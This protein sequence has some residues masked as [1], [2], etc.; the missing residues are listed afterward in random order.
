MTRTSSSDWEEVEGAAEAEGSERER[1]CLTQ[2]YINIYLSLSFSLTCSDLEELERGR[3]GDIKL[4]SYLI[5]LLSYPDT[6]CPGSSDPTL[7]IESITI[8]SN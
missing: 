1:V 3:R 8:L 4:L 5:F 7:N 6:V 2:V